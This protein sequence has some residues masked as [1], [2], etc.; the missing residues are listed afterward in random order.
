MVWA[1]NAVGYARFGPR[2]RESK[3]DGD[4]GLVVSGAGRPGILSR[5]Q[6]E[7]VLVLVMMTVGND[8]QC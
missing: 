8:G 7:T 1:V 5:S 4:W 6:P 3:G 2:R